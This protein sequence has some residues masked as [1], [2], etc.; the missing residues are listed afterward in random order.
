V[1]GV[2]WCLFVLVLDVGVGEGV[3]GFFGLCG[4]VYEGVV[5]GVEGVWCVV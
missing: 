2:G 1:F 3:F 4:E 5:E